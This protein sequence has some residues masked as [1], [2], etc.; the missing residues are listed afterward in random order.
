MVVI[1]GIFYLDIDE[2]SLENDDCHDD[3]ICTDIIG[4]Y[5]CQCK[6]G[7]IGDGKHCQGKTICL[8][9]GMIVSI[10]LL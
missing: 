9:H 8:G 3:A 1:Y 4:S 10:L 5:T 7:F 2:C 6:E